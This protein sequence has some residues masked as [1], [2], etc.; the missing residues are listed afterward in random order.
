MILNK[1]Q[2]DQQKLNRMPNSE[3]QLYVG[4]QIIIG[5]IN[6]LR[7]LLIY[8]PI[9]S[10]NEVIV[11][12]ENSQ[13]IFVLRI[14]AGKLFESWDFL[15]KAFFT[16][17]L[18]IVYESLLDSK[19]KKSLQKLKQY[20]GRSHPLSK[21]RNKFAFH[22]IQGIQELINTL[23]TFH[24]SDPM[25]IYIAEE[26]GNCYYSMTQQLLNESLVQSFNG[27]DIKEKIESLFDEIFSNANYFVELFGSLIVVITERHLDFHCE[28]IEIPDPPLITDIKL[29]YF[30]KRC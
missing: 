21:V 8:Q 26:N 6:Y 2:I 5:E 9:P 10:E 29:P 28:E 14:L 12:A 23:Q 18:S 17:K 13:M 27:S 22:Y 4:S 7:K 24:E 20:F 25:E 30:S 11:S 19:G 16:T 3:L 15:E 1:V